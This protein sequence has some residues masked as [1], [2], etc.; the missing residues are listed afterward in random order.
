MTIDELLEKL[1]HAFPSFNAR[2]L[3]VWA[4]VFR[5]NLE[6]H[7][8]A[9]LRDAFHAVL[10]SF[11]VTKSKSLHP[12]PADFIGHLP[13]MHPKL[14]SSGPAL[15][16]RGHR[17]RMNS[18]MSMWRAGQGLRGSKGVEEVLRA[19]EFIAQPIAEAAAWSENPEPVQ[20]T[21]KQ[22]RLAQY[23]AVSQQR[24]IEHGNLPRN[25]DDWWSQISA[26]AERWGIQTTREEWTTPTPERI[27]A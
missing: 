2:A 1:A 5:A 19:L 6:R 26:I 23:R 14:P 21:G 7:E 3:A 13:S 24:R 12:V 10:S 25:A 22:L 15:D 20:L 17:T 18:L 11:S 16:V 4:P 8:G 27:A 9:A